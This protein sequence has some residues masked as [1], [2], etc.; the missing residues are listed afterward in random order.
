[1]GVGKGPEMRPF[2]EL[3]G[4]EEAMDLI[5]R[6]VEK[7]KR[8]EEVKLDE[9]DGRILAEDI[10]AR[11][12]VPPFDRSAMDGYALHASDTLNASEETPAVLKIIGKQHAADLF[13]YTISLGECVVIS[14][15]APIPDGAD[16]VVMVEYTET[17]GNL[18][19]VF[20]EVK[21]GRN[22]APAGEDMKKGNRVLDV[23][24]HITPGKVGTLAALGYEKVKVYERPRIGIYS[25]GPEIV[26]QN[27]ELGPGQIYDINSF[28]LSSV[29]KRNG[30]VPLRRGVIPDDYGS[31]KEA[32]LEGS[33]FD[34][35]VLS[36]GSSVGS[37]DLF[38]DVIQEI[39]EIVFHGV[40]VKPGKPTL[41]GKVDGTPVFGMP[42]YP[43]SC[44]NNSYVFLTPALRKM[45]GLPPVNRREI[46]V[47]MGHRMES[48][49]DREQFITVR[50]SDG[51]AF[52]VY[53]QSGDITS[54]TH[55][56]GFM[57]LSI[58]KS[59]INEGEHVEVTLF[60]Y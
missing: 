31:I 44:L 59:I 41:F 42:G 43:T 16:A 5:L 45:A 48:K 50:V 46:T 56:D 20:K 10:D 8:V 13:D 14:T 12:H 54:M 6:N 2:K 30:A 29:I 35:V 37:K 24:E 18:V 9:S 26:P 19:N 15:G 53:K 27:Q 52:R 47:P 21:P 40:R 51:K 1:M 57:I 60:N 17:E 25:S 36:G 39:G 33:K 23:G 4:R 49:S 11:A 3:T 38:A 34:L 28:T 32:I 7:I 58:G 22:I 55:A